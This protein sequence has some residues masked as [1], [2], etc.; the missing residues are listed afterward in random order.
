MAISAL[1][2]EKEDPSWLID[3]GCSAHVTGNPSLI[4]N[5]DM[6]NPGAVMRTAGNQS[7]PAEGTGVV[8]LSSSGEIK[9]N[10]VYYVP[11]ISWNL[12][13]VGAVADSRYTLVFD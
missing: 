6:T 13:S 12:L 9:L 5:L 2:L 10:N 11:G 3:S 4:E 7:L 8:N 1:D